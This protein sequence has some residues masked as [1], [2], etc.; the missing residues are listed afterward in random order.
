MSESQQKFDSPQAELKAAREWAHNLKCPTCGHDI[1]DIQQP[2]CEDG[3]L[4]AE[5]GERHKGCMCEMEPEEAYIV[6]AYR[7]ARELDAAVRGEYG[8]KHERD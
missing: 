1:W 2:E 8:C 4:P 5:C 6:L 3:R 7:F